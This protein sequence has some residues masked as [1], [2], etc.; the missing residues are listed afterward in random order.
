M[1]CSC[2]L[3]KCMPSAGGTHVVLWPLYVVLAS[4]GH[5]SLKML[6]NAGN[7]YVFF[8]IVPK[9]FGVKSAS[10]KREKDWLNNML[11]NFDK[12]YSTF[13]KNWIKYSIDQ[14]TYNSTMNNNSLIFILLIMMSRVNVLLILIHASLTLFIPTSETT[15]FYWGWCYFSPPPNRFPSREA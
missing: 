2:I 8:S 6:K 12:R 11:P 13:K 10:V 1:S 15:D 3:H 14:T 9:I 7:W 4:I 5:A